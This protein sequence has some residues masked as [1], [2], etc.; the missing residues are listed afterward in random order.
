V[1]FER[2][3]G[4]AGR[5]NT[6]ESQIHPSGYVVRFSDHN[7]SLTH[8]KGEVYK[9]SACEHG[10]DTEP[11]T[12]VEWTSKISSRSRS[13]DVE[14]KVIPKITLGCCLQFVQ[15]LGEWWWRNP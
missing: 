11:V 13:A 10:L 2:V 5:G 7:A 4:A 8:I 15:R 12:T 14:L 6:G 9:F 3:N 1:I